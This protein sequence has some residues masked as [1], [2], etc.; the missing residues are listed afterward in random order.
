MRSLLTD[1]RKFIM[2]GNLLQ[3]AVAFILALYFADVVNAFTKGI[4]LPFVAAIFGKPSFDDIGVNIGDIMD[5]DAPDVPLKPYDKIE[6]R[7]RL[8]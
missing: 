4:V 1:F 3:I 8:F 7:Q 2:K 5:G 6:V